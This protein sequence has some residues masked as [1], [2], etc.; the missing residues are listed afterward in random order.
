MKLL[1]RQE[2]YS[3]RDFRAR[4]AISAGKS[5]VGRIEYAV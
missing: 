1:R 5:L 4:T 3:L 2:N